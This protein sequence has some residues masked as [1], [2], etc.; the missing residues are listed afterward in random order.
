MEVT[1]ASLFD[2]IGGAP[3]STLMCGAECLW[4][5]EIE[6]FPIKVT[7]HHFPNMKHHGDIAKING[8]EVEPVD[9]IVGGSPCQ[10]LSVAGKR[11]GMKHSDFGD[12]DGTRSGLF[13]DQIR[14]VKEMRNG[15]NGANP[16]FMVWENVPGAFSSA[17]GEDF[18]AV[19]EETARVAEPTISI[20]RSPD[21]WANSGSIMGDGFS[22]SWR[23]VDA[24]YWGV[25]QRRRRIYLVADFRGQS[26]PEILFEQQ[27]M[28]WHPTQ[29]VGKTQETA[30]EIENCTRTKIDAQSKLRIGKQQ[31]LFELSVFRQGAFANY[32][33][34]EYG[35][36]KKSGGD[37]GGGTETLVTY[38]NITG[39]LM[40]NT[41]PGSYSGQDAY[42]DMFVT[43][44][45][46]RRLTP[47]ECERLQ[48]YPD[49]WT[50]IPPQNTITD[51]DILFWSVVW[52]SYDDIMGNNHHSDKQ[53]TTWLKSVSTDSDR[54]KSLGNSFAIPN[55][56]FVIGGCVNRI[57]DSWLI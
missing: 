33:E 3:W 22:I 18:R 51:D 25:P 7:K 29:S 54:Y 2:G 43:N 6:P 50:D 24:Q 23:T 46:V 45:S 9:I 35:T 52:N 38:Q 27:G 37:I 1:I 57:K 26:A 31:T 44:K 34:G 16:R 4:S 15:T 12:E 41:H 53:I 36:L 56:Y 11:A 28:Y 30:R 55:A 19:L 5:S 39:S 13:M 48:G 20:P 40:A 10:D 42:C 17:N 32:V 21:G 47:L 8:V 49:G 14:I